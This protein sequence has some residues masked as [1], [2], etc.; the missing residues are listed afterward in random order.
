MNNSAASFFT[1]DEK[2]RISAVTRQ[3]ELGTSGEVA[4]MVV[5]SSDPYPDAEI[6]AGI[7]FGSL[8]AF[9]CTEIFFD[10]L[11][12]YYIPLSILFFF[13]FR[14][15][16]GLI[17]SLKTVF[18]SAGRKNRTVARRALNA[19]YEKGLYRTRDNTGVLFFISLM[20]HKVWVLAD[21][22]IYSKIDQETMNRF[23]SMVT[24][25]IK[26]GRAC[27]ALCSAI[28]E[29]GAILATHFPVKPDDTNELSD[30]VMTE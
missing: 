10:A 1:E 5:G 8:A 9:A 16:T 17:P 2:Q 28:P 21:K 7:V 26:E 4:V 27:D 23:A 24:Q 13:P 30:D 14:R 11:I 22:G 19:F 6:T 12:W 20:E 15:L 18:I 25:G 3:V 29:I